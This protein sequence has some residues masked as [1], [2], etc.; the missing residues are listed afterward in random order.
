MRHTKHVKKVCG[1]NY[2]SGAL[3]NYWQYYDDLKF[4]NLF[5]VVRMNK[6]QTTAPDYPKISATSI[7]TLKNPMN[8]EN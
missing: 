8:D 5:N 2:S 3:C 4:I 7:A 1:N 6:S